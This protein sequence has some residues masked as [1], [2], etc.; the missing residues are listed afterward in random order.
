MHL[1]FGCDIEKIHLKT[2]LYLLSFTAA[3][4]ENASKR[5]SFIQYTELSDLEA[6]TAN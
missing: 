5:T 6:S 4:L 1:S 2:V 3:V